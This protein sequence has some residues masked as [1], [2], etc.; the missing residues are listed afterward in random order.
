MSPV[1]KGRMPHGCHAAQPAD[2]AIVYHDQP[3]V[4][5]IA[6][7]ISNREE[8]LQLVQQ[9]LY[10]RYSHLAEETVEGLM[11][12]FGGRERFGEWDRN[13]LLVFLRTVNEGST[14]LDL[15]L[16]ATVSNSSEFLPDGGMD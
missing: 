13:T 10:I 16:L 2:S 8:L 12:E 9:V 5:T 11:E 1:N 3:S 6:Q 7:E 15:D 4:Q 14:D